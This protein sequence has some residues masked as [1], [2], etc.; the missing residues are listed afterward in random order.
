MRPA[1]GP[2]LDA[3][4]GCP[5]RRRVRAI[6][7]YDASI[8]YGL[9]APA[10][11]P[12]AVTARLA[13]WFAAALQDPTVKAKLAAQGLRPVGLCGAAFGDYVRGQYRDYGDVIRKADIRAP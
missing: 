7:G 13:G 8:W 1:R 4:A 6:P 11:T 3:F 9:F 10:G 12:S 2:E 5:G